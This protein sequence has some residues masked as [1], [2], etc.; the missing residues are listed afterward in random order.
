LV[1]IFVLADVKYEERNEEIKRIKEE[2]KKKDEEIKRKDETIKKKDENIKNLKVEKQN[3]KSTSSSYS[4]FPQQTPPPQEP[5][6][7]PQQDQKGYYFII[8]CT[9]SEIEFIKPLDD[10]KIQQ[11]TITFTTDYNRTVFINKVINSGIMR[12]FIFFY[13]FYIYI[14]YF[15]SQVLCICTDNRSAFSMRNIF[16]LL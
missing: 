1:H 5:V 14:F 3:L 9:Y 7:S 15:V 11:Q 4:S 13:N 16:F 2:N 8:N 12:M 6:S 10:V